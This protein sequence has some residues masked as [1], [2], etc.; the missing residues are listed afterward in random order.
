MLIPRPTAVAL[1]AEQRLRYYAAR[2]PAVEVNSSY[3]ALPTVRKALRMHN[4][5]AS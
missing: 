4:I 5:L 3:Y 1:S 2:F